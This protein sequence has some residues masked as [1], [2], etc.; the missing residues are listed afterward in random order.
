MLTITDFLDRAAARDPDKPAI[1][2]RDR[3]MTF[4]EMV[5]L[6]GQSA[7][8]LAAAG[9][10]PGMRVGLG[11]RDSRDYLILFYALTALGAITLPVDWRSRSADTAGHLDR[12]G[13]ELLFAGAS[14][15]ASHNV[16]TLVLDDQWHADVAAAT[17]RPPIAADPDRPFLILLSSGTTGA[18]EGRLL[19]HAQWRVRSRNFLTFPGFG[20]DGRFLLVLPLF[21]AAGILNSLAH[22]KVGNTVIIRPN[23]FDARTLVDLIDDSAA[24]HVLAVPS[25]IR[26]LL[27]HLECDRPRFPDLR[28]LSV[29]GATLHTDEKT[30]TTRCLTPNLHETYGTAASGLATLLVGTDLATH[31]HSVGRAL[32]HMTVQ[33]VDDDD[34]PLPLGTRGLI[35]LKGPGVAID[36]A[37]LIGEHTGDDDG[38][39]HTGD[40][41]R[42]DDNGLLYLDGRAADVIIRNGVNIYPHEIEE[43]LMRHSDVVEAAVFGYDALVSGEEVAAAVVP[44]GSPTVA[45]LTRHCRTA[46]ANYKVPSHIHFVDDMPRT[47]S[48]KVRKT[49]LRER[50]G[51][52]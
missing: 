24:T 1:V 3:T 5:R 22:L 6:V 12:F 8:C 29:T 27:G 26:M 30:A 37:R 20:P 38:W 36:T 11:A 45:A 7:D 32:P 40:Y 10:V 44:R 25:M 47:A 18:P 43:H 48:G 39:Y 16:P 21:L 2:E 28:M 52:I 50:F 51:A 19:I 41:G 46:L 23:L 33:I 9:V 13:A 31:P 35:R 4:G 17:P 14:L 15:P 34:R 42:L 49:V